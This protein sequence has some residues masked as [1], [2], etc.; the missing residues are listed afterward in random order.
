MKWKVVGEIRKTLFGEWEGK[1]IAIVEGLQ[2][3]PVRPISNTKVE[4]LKL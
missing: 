4:T 2:A 3:G 1:R